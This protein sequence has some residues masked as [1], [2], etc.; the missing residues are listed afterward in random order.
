LQ[1]TLFSSGN[2]PAVSRMES[3]PEETS[4]ECAEHILYFRKPS[5]RLRITFFSSGNL[6][7]VCRAYSLLQ[8]TFLQATGSFL[9]CRKACCCDGYIFLLKNLQ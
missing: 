1:E 3:L 6:P 9:A 2:L 4:L 5:C 8:E 7:I